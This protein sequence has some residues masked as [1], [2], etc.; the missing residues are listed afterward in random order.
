MDTYLPTAPSLAS[1]A[2][3]PQLRLPEGVSTRELPQSDG[4]ISTGH[5]L[6]CELM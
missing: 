2:N 4:P 5:S 6:N 1:A 3:L